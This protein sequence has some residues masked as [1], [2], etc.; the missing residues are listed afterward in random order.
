MAQTQPVEVLLRPPVELYTVAVCAGAALLCVA[1]PWS[2]ALSPEIGIGSALVF[3]FFG[4]LRWR[5]AQVI[6][7][8]RRNIRRLPRYVM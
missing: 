6:L 3:G 7:R 2:L 5:D 1:A 8:Y 4:V